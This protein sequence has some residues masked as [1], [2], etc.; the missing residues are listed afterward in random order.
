MTR[1]DF[2]KKYLVRFGVSLTLLGLIV[3]TVYH[4]FASS[5]GSLMKL[6]VQS[7]TERLTASGEAY[8]FRD[9]AVLRTSSEGLIDH[10]V[11]SGVK[12]SRGVKL[13]EVYVNADTAAQ[14]ELDALNRL[15]GILEAG[16]N[17]NDKTVSGADS[18]RAEANAEYLAIC[19]AART[20]D[21]SRI[22]DCS[23]AMLTALNKYG[24]LTGSTEGQQETL[25]ALK[26]E[27]NKL[28]TGTPIA[29]YNETSSGYFYDRT[30]VDGYES[31][32]ST[33]A[34][35]GLTPSRLQELCDLPAS[36]DEGFA[37]GKM[38]YDYDWYLAIVLTGQSV[39]LLREGGEYSFRFPDNRDA[40][41]QMRCHRI[42]AEENGSFVV[43]FHSDEV[44][45]NFLY[46][47]HQR[48]EIGVGSLVGYYIP[49]SAL[50]TVNGVEGVYIFL[51]SAVYFRRVE[52][53]HR[54]EGYAVAAEQGERGEEYLALHDV[55]VTS[56]KDLY[57][58]RMYR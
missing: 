4:V 14:T 6:P 39:D 2:L 8:L 10:T 19:Q 27:K 23:D 37:V 26:E 58:G 18:L 9:E 47:R 52:I 28:L 57:D 53:L 5:E 51:D 45:T 44:P 12:V 34:L 1:K 30:C 36:V 25:N 24:V 29:L 13:S 3:Y 16:L 15:I 22:P 21:W 17:E 41:L 50:H 54:G 35:D 55:L 7:Y 40:T 42:S 20:G 48:V 31:L 38:A 56:G 33:E 49:E 46:L 32:F 43:I 11:E